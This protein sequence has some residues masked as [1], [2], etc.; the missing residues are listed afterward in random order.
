LLH[1]VATRLI[2]V[3]LELVDQLADA[4]IL[5]GDDTSSRVV[6]VN[7]YLD[8]PEADRPPPPW[9]SYRTQQVAS[10]E[11]NQ[12]GSLSLAVPLASELGFEFPLSKR[13][14]P[15]QSFNTTTVSGRSHGD[16]PR[17]LVVLYRSHLGGFGNLLEVL[18]EKRKPK[19]RLRT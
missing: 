12:Q 8:Q 1:Y 16:D 7:S 13:P 17:S 9:A 14:G 6:E 19:S 2:A 10:E 15:K 5:M 18:L 11:L 3:Y 4:P